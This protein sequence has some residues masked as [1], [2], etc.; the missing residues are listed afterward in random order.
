MGIVYV[1]YDHELKEVYAA[2]TFSDDVFQRSPQIEERF[3]QEALTWVRLDAHQNV[4]QSE[5]LFKTIIGKPYIFLEYVSGGDLR[6]WIGTSH[7]R[8]IGGR[9]CGFGIQFCDGMEHA[10]SRG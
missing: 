8:E 6:K 10:R 1:V 2:K 9:Y 4:I 7:C 3:Q 5:I